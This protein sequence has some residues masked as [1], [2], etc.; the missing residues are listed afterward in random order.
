MCHER[1][2][3]QLGRCKHC[4]LTRCIECGSV[5]AVFVRMLETVK[6]RKKQ[7]Q[8]AVYE[9]YALVKTRTFERLCIN[10]ECSS[11]LIP[12]KCPPPGSGWKPQRSWQ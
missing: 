10:P 4:Q 8:I 5:L 1:K 7:W 11:T 3:K 12:P 2:V 6:F 9:H